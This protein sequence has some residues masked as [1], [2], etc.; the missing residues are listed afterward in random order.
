MWRI[1]QQD[2]PDDYVLATGETHTVREF[3]E[4][5]FRVV[6]R[7]IEWHGK[8]V[9]EKGRCQKSGD[10]L[11]A[12]DPAYFRPTEVDLLLGDPSKAWDRLGWRHT[13][14]FDDLVSEMVESDMR[15]LRREVLTN[16]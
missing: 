7:P 11:V 1:L 8:G 2:E 3:V 4:K 15:T 14:S 6:G 12:I 13:T 10:V 9:A 16:A 5:A